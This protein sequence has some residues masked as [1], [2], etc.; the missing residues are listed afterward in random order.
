M[1]K[2]KS[3][4]MAKIFFGFL[5]GDD[6]L[7]NE[8]DREFFINNLSLFTELM[9][10]QAVE[11]LVTQFDVDVRAAEMVIRG[12]AILNKMLGGQAFADFAITESL[13]ELSE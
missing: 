2:E 10:D 3:D 12:T 5:A 1:E 6:V 13:A 7:S 8:D 11:F 9:N 4:R